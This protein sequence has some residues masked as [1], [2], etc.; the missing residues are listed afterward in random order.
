MTVAESMPQ[1]DSGAISYVTEIDYPSPDRGPLHHL[2][3]P[4]AEPEPLPGPQ[5]E[6]ELEAG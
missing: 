5:L 1:P 2:F 3:L 4:M 6:P